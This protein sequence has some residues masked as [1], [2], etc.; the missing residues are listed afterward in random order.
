MHM[1]PCG[2]H[3]CA[4]AHVAMLIDDDVVGDFA[5]VAYCADFPCARDDGFALG[6]DAFVA[7]YGYNLRPRR[8]ENAVIF[9]MFIRMQFVH[10]SA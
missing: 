5:F 2:G 7:V 1:H 8:G 10:G 3:E 4:N 9:G 6:D